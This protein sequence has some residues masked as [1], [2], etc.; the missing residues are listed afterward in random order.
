RRLEDELELVPLEPFYRLYFADGE[1][2]DYSGQP[3]RM[4]AEIARFSPADAA[5]HDA[6]FR[7]IGRIYQ[8][9]VVELGDKPFLHWADF[10]R[11]IPSMLALRA[12]RPVTSTVGDFF[13]EPHVFR[14]L[15]FQPLF[16]G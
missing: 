7:H 15:S 8:R 5:R 9:A 13:R 10:A 14:A 11:I 6:F 12:L 2:F 1:H 16:I 3:E 4:R